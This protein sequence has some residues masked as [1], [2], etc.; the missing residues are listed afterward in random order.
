LI[1]WIDAQLSPS[2]GRWI[3]TNFGI[4]SHAIREL[5]MLR[6]KDREIFHSAREAEAV[7]MTKDAD[8]LE[9]VQRHGPPPQILWVTCGNTSNARLRH[10]LQHALPLAVQH[11]NDGEPLVEISDAG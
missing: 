10:I 7:I 4:E 5:G 1:L 6:A 9:L 11:L 8:F 3:S 2:I